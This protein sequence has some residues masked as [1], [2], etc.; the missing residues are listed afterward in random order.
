M[1]EFLASMQSVAAR[2]RQAHDNRAEDLAHTRQETGRVLS[3]AQ[4]QLRD[5]RHRFNTVVGGARRS[6]MEGETDRRGAAARAREARSLEH[7]AHAR[8]MRQAFAA[9]RDDLCQHEE[10][11]RGRADADRSSRQTALRERA[12]TLAQAFDNCR[13]NRL[14]SE[15]ARRQRCR[16]EKNE[17]LSH[18]GQLTARVASLRADVRHTLAD[19]RAEVEEGFRVFHGLSASAAPAAPPVV[20]RATAEATAPPAAAPIPAPAAPQEAATVA[21]AAP[22]AGAAAI[23]ALGLSERVGVLLR[24]GGINTIDEL[25][26]TSQEALLALPGIGPGSVREIQR[27]LA[28]RGLSLPD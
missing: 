26:R 16:L 4:G 28:N 2:I 8:A 25:L 17:I 21:E 3:E 22:A 7:A 24:E 10:Q 20:P 13:K 6:R 9:L 18:V 19:F 14:D 11:R 27:I 15:T 12:D 1:A 5:L 23:G